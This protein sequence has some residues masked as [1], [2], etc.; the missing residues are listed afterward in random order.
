MLT[1]F[2]PLLWPCWQNLPRHR[3]RQATPRRPHQRKSQKRNSRRVETGGYVADLELFEEFAAG[4]GNKDT[5]RHVAFA[6]L[7]ALNDARGLATLGA[8]GALGRIHHFL[9]VRRLGDLGHG[10]YSPDVWV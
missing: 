6:V 5:A 7:D 8:I 9:A 10:K 4:A 1:N 2:R 3:Q